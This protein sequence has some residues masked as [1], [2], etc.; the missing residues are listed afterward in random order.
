M[1]EEL[2]EDSR[3]EPSGDDSVIS[4]DID[5]VI[6][7]FSIG[8]M[9]I[10]VFLLNINWSNVVFILLTCHT[11][12]NFTATSHVTSCTCFQDKRF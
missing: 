7:Y 9:K 10:F 12:L 11:Q 6:A 1:E 2:E 5:I 4:S 8:I 3:A